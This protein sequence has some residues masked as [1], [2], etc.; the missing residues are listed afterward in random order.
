[1]LVHV[2][3]RWNSKQVC[4]T[5]E[6]ILERPPILPSKVADTIERLLEEIEKGEEDNYRESKGI[7]RVDRVDSNES[8]LTFQ[9][10][11]PKDSGGN[12]RSILPT[13]QRLQQRTGSI[14]LS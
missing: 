12:T 14:A 11:G 6:N 10:P 7:K 9:L 5:L 1:M 8:R 4:E 2:D 3:E 13:A